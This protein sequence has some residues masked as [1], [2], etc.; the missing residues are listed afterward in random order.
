MSR[1]EAVAGL[2]TLAAF[3]SVAAAAFAAGY[4][5]GSRAATR[6]LEPYTYL[7]QVIP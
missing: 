6:A 1:I 5:T 7:R 3:L 2:V 4:W